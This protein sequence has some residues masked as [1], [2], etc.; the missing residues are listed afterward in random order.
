MPAFTVV[1]RGLGKP[2]RYLERFAAMT[3]AGKGFRDLNAERGFDLQVTAGYEGFGQD[4][5]DHIRIGRYHYAYGP[6]IAV[7][8]SDRKLKTVHIP[9]IVGIAEVMI[10]MATLYRL[11]FI[12]GT[13]GAERI[14]VKMEIDKL[15]TVRRIV[16]IPDGAMPAQHIGFIVERN[17]DLVI[18]LL[19]PVIALGRQR[20]R[21]Q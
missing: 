20:A 11:F 1:Y 10:G 14:G 7:I 8:V 17:G 2:L 16:L 9:A 18:H 21:Q 3:Q 5:F 15:K 4:Q 13:V 19:L 6:G 12:S